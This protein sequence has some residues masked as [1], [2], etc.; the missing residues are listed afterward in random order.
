M[1][2]FKSVMIW[3]FMILAIISLIIIE[4]LTHIVISGIGAGVLITIFVIMCWSAIEMLKIEKK[5]TR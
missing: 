4:I 3:L 2:L 5:V 1:K